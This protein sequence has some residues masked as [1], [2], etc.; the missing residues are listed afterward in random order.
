MCL[1]THSADFRPD[2]RPQVHAL[3]R[4]CLPAQ[5]FLDYQA[6]LAKSDSKATSMVS[7]RG[8]GD[9]LRGLGELKGA[10]KEYTRSIELG[11]SVTTSLQNPHWILRVKDRGF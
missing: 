4:A 5:A 3:A 9:A 1:G 2:G 8:L 11:L 7:R 10:L 6:V